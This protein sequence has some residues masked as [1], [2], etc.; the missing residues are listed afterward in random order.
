M[1]ELAPFRVVFDSAQLLVVEKPAGVVTHPA[2]RNLTGTLTD[3]VEWWMLERDQQ[4]PWLLHRL[5]RDTSGLVLFAKTP[6]AMRYCARQFIEHTVEKQYLA[7]I[8]GN[9]L[10]ESGMIDAA[11]MRD[12]EDRRRVIVAR[13]GQSAQTRFAIQARWETCALVALWPLT[14]RTHQLRAHLAWLGH[15][16]I[17]DSVY[18]TEQPLLAGVTRL[19]LHAATLTLRAPSDG[20]PRLRTFLAPLPDDFLTS[21]AAATHDQS[22]APPL[23][24]IL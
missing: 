16:I 14:G 23:T 19:L 21:L 12:P 1:P 17:G 18:A 8:W 5:D 3:A 9:D 4:R 10:P 13:G 24:P 11:L 6:E 15:P 22:S 20:G 2:Y 7:L